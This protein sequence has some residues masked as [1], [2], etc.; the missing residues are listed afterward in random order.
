MQIEMKNVIIR[1]SGEKEGQ[2]LRQFMADDVEWAA[3]QIA[4]VNNC[5]V[6]VFESDG[7]HMFTKEPQS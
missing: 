6:K 5:T 3:Q 7:T 2:M 4:D 1:L